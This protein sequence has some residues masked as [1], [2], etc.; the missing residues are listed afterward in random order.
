MYVVV[1]YDIICDRR[2]GRLF[3]RMKDYLPRV[4]KSVFEG[5]MPES[6]FPK[7]VDMIK[8]QM[9]QNEDT[10]RIYHLCRSCTPAVQIMGTGPMVIT[11]L[12]D[13][14]I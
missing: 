5:E 1:C 14:I 12:E 4:Q 6:R 10:V 8:E 7:M 13:I 3:R 2:R 11:E 9:D